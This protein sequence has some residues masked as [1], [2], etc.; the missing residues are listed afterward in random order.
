MNSKRLF[1]ALLWLYAGWIVAAFVG[2]LIGV[3][4]LIGPAGGA[5]AAVF[6]AGDPLHIIWAPRVSTKQINA[7]L[8]SVS[9]PN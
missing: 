7:G 8:A 2:M 5:V 6:F 1:A 4:G 9:A 3:N